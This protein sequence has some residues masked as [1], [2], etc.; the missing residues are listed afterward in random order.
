[1]CYVSGTGVQR[2]H[3][4]QI[5]PIAIPTVEG[6]EL[7]DTEYTKGGKDNT[8]MEVRSSALTW[9]EIRSSHDLQNNSRHRRNKIT[10]SV[11]C[12]QKKHK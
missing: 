9:K 2:L 3:L 4:S 6:I 8:D 1:M 12:N 11:G 10:H 7:V 5:C